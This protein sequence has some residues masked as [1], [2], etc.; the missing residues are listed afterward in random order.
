MGLS[1]KTIRTLLVSGLFL[2]PAAFGSGA[3]AQQPDFDFGPKSKRPTFKDV[4]KEIRSTIEPAEAKRGQ[5]VTWKLT[6]R[7]IPEWHTYPVRQI[8]ANAS[9]QVTEVE[10]KDPEKAGVK[11]VGGIKDPPGFIAK[12]EPVLKIKELRYYEGEVV[13]TR[14]LKVLPQTEPGRRIVQTDVRI[15]V[16]DKNGC[17]PPEDVS[18]QAPLVVNSAPAVDEPEPVETDD[19]PAASTSKSADM[20]WLGFVLAGVFWGAISLITPCVFPMIPITVSFFL[21]QSEKEHHRPLAMALVYCLTIVAVLTLAAVL[22][23]RTFQEISQLWITNVLLGGLFI[24]FALSLFGMYEIELPSGLA[25]FTSAREGQGGTVG[26]IFMALT[27]TIVS[28]ACVA[29]FMGGFAGLSTSETRPM[30]Q[31]ILGGLAFSVTFASPFFFL[32]L[33]PTLLRKMPKS[34]SWLNS[35]KVIMGFLELAAALKFL[36]AGE[37]VG[38]SKAE[39]LTYDLVLGMYVAISLLCGLY[40]LNVY[41]LP[42]DSP[43]EHLG[44]PRLLFA[45]LFIS[46]GFYLTPALFQ[47]D[48]TSKQRPN[49]AVFAWLDS[50]LL[51]DGQEIWIGD[52]KKGLQTARSEGKRVFVDFT[53]V[54]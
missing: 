2:L 24:F 41:R 26:T 44:V 31:I 15:L 25:R 18:L 49:G 50:F 4:V 16:C 51:R 45:L 48:A 6:V 7:L 39:F 8:D 11:L 32:A 12:E 52:L 38:L 46:L 29:P 33:F 5:I 37:L 10:F 36:R 22:L 3:S 13:W 19:A 40:L 21:K 9:S 35:V 42:H 27:F 20:D 30:W 17:L 23:V 53:G 47:Y 28:F 43:A 34:G 54:T 1:V 14:K